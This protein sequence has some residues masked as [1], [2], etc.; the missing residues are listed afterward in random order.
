VARVL[1]T[2]MSGAGKTT[3]LHEMA[4]RGHRTLDTDNGG[5]VLPDGH[6]DPARMAQLLAEHRDIIVSGTVD[7]QADFYDQFDVVVLLSAPLP[8]L[9]R[10]AA[11]RTTNPYGSSPSDREEI[12]RNTEHVEPLLRAG[13]DLE[14]DGQ[15]PV[16]TL[17]DQLEASITDTP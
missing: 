7:N 1:I 5:W 10:R 15:L 3:L 9:L 8:V 12:R 2:G 14:L 13:A 4:R 6:W 16:G 11:A 17:A